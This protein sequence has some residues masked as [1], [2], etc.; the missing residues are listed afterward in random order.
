[1][2]MEFCY[3]CGMPI[4]MMPEAKS[5]LENYCQHCVDEKGEV[6]PYE[7]IKAGVAMW[8]K[9]WQP[10]VDETEAQKRADSYLQAMPKWAGE[11]A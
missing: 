9:S 11:N 6:H 10:N 4:S 5:S 3:S 7:Q 8:L 1:M 2:E